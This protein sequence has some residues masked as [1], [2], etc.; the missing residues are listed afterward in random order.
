MISSFQNTSHLVETLVVTLLQEALSLILREQGERRVNS[1]VERVA[2]LSQFVSFVV[3][4]F[5]L[6]AGTEAVGRGSRSVYCTLDDDVR[7]EFRRLVRVIARVCQC[8]SDHRLAVKISTIIVRAYSLSL[9]INSFIPFPLP[10][11][12]VLPPRTMAMAVSTADFP[13]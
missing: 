1:D 8:E 3:Q 4:Y 9:A 11:S 2:N 7:V 10:V 5:C 13:P 12:D 6:F